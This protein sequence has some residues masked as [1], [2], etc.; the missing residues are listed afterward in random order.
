MRASRWL[1]D[2]FRRLNSRE[3]IVVIGGA[4]V[5]T[6]ALLAVLVVLPQAR[7]WL[8]RE[9]QIAMLAE[10]LARLESLVEREDAV[11]DRLTALE[12]ERVATARQLLEGET[13]AV[14]ASSLQLLLNRYATESRVELDRVDAVSRP[15]DTEGITEIPARIAVRGDI[16][17]LVDLLFYLQNGEKLLV[18]DELRV[19][20]VPTGRG[21]AELLTVSVSLHGYYRSGGG[22]P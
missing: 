15:A 7:R 14:A 11:R 22:T 12:A 1:S 4:A 18:V 2:T 8:E 3:R 20:Q 13:T 16:Y 9:D 5:S 17:G 21:M 6:V 19:G 10:Q